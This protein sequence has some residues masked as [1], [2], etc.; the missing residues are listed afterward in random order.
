MKR[1]LILLLIPMFLLAPIAKAR[2]SQAGAVFLIIY[3][4]ARPNGMGAAFTAIAD[5][6]LGLLILAIFYPQEEVQLIW[7]LLPVIAVGIGMLFQ[8]LRFRSFWWYLGIPGIISWI[9]FAKAGLHPALGLLP[10]IPTIP[11]AHCD[12]GLFNWQE[13]NATDSLNRF[14]YWW[15]NPV[16]L[17]LMLFGLLNAGV[18]FSAI[19][20]PTYL[21][22]IGLIASALAPPRRVARGP[23]APP[24]T[25][26]TGTRAASCPRPLAPRPAAA[27]L[28]I[29]ARPRNGAPRV[30]P[31]MQ[32]P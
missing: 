31:S 14:Q 24:R 22:M 6:A 9:G 29:P 4:G 12:Q 28:G 7:M 17:I 15:K 26:P 16:E 18:V 1:K 23:R 11:H 19:D 32:R 8:R 27:I 13:L 21:I 25:R 5:D 20:A 10:I 2:T 3:P 30:A